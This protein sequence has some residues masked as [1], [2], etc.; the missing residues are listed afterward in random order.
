MHYLLAMKC[1]NI[2]RIFPIIDLLVR[3]FDAVL[4]GVQPLCMTQLRVKYQL[5][6]HTDNKSKR[7]SDWLS[8]LPR[9]KTLISYLALILVEYTLS[10]SLFL[11]LPVT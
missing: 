3:H 9:N 1:A 2:M 5:T 8:I 4:R 11:H 10:I 7:R 6:I